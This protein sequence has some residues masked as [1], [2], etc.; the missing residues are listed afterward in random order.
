MLVRIF[1]F[2]FIFEDGTVKRRFLIQLFTGKITAQQ[3][4]QPLINDV[5][6]EWKLLR[7]ERE[8]NQEELVLQSRRAGELNELIKTL[9]EEKEFLKIEKDR[10]SCAESLSIQNLSL[11]KGL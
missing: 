6:S 4:K 8:R 9:E 3:L 1:N 2:L 10:Y 11:L 7:I 5:V